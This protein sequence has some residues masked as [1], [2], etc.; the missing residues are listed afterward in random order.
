MA[1][2]TPRRA[3]AVGQD[4]GAA[5]LCVLVF[6]LPA[7]PPAQALVALVVVGMLL[8]S[9]WPLPAFVLVAAAT[10]TGAVAG[11]TDDP[12]LAAAW[13]LYP[14]A[15]R[16]GRRR[17]LPSVP[18]V[19]AVGIG[20]L[21][22]AGPAEAG[23]ATR[24]AMTSLPAPAAAWAL[25]AQVRHGRLAAEQATRAERDRAVAEE[26]LRVIR[27]VHDV[28]SHS[29]GTI[30]ITSGV[31]LHVGGDAEAMRGRLARIESASRRALDELRGVLRAVRDGDDG[32][33]RGPRPGVQDLPGL[34]ER[35]RQAGLPVELTMT[36]VADVPPGAGLAA[37]R[38]VQEAL[39][40]VGRHAPG[41]RCR[42]RVTGGGAVH[43][44]VDDDGRGGTGD[45]PPGYGLIGLRER[46][47]LLGGTFTAG[48]RPDGGFGVRAVIP[49]RVQEAADA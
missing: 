10:L 22:L 9:W 44:E 3:G 14:V 15:L 16:W 5:L 27:E 23:A 6:W 41:A 25:G 42:V 2:F 30:A 18:V 48:P 12:F 32:A 43:V 20:L 36:D 37:Y 7:D 47:E 8:R 29:L 24:Y 1:F 17:F 31:A 34:V 40:N 13:T 28:V 26:R 45:G 39:T 49:V 19:V 21:A 38:V 46:V 11:V 35:S 33:E 4:L